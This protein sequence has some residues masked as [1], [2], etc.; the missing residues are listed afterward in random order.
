MYFSLQ[1]RVIWPSVGNCAFNPLSLEDLN[2]FSNFNIPLCI[3][4]VV[5]ESRNKLRSNIVF[6]A[7]TWHA[8]MIA[9]ECESN[10]ST[11]NID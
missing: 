4:K 5:F 9:N 2:S 11:C 8:Y 7:Q 6:Q 1:E 10:F 3:S